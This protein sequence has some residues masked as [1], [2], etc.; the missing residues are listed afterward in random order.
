[1]IGLGR[2]RAAT[3]QFGPSP[4]DAARTDVYDRQELVPGVRFEGPAVLTQ[5]DATTVV[6]PGYN[7]RVDA[8]RQI[9]IE[10]A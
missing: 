1:M 3:V 8:Q 7:A 9:W 2:S 5:A 10:R 4:G 6:P